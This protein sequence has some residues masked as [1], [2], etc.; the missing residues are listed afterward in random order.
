MIGNMRIIKLLLVVREDRNLSEIE[1]KIADVIGVQIG[2]PI[3][4][5][6]KEFIEILEW[7]IPKKKHIL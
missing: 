2:E 4:G 6:N 1:E 3:K 5:K 7:C